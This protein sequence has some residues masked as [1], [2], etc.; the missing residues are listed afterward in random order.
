MG[1]YFKPF[2]FFLPE[3]CR[4]PHPRYPPLPPL[5]PTTL[6]LSSLN[7]WGSLGLCSS[8][9]AK[10]LEELVNVRHFSGVQRAEMPGCLVA[11]A[12]AEAQL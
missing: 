9:Q 7:G 12:A 2:F 8:A 5:L 11:A 3:S 4:H 6:P 10:R 1:N